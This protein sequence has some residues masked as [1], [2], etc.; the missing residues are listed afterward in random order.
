MPPDLFLPM[1]SLTWP[2]PI[3]I[4]FPFSAN[5]SIDYTVNPRPSSFVSLS[6]ANLSRMHCVSFFVLPEGDVKSE[7]FGLWYHVRV[8][9]E[10]LWTLKIIFHKVNVRWCSSKSP[11][12]EQNLTLIT[13]FRLKKKRCLIFLLYFMELTQSSI[14]NHY[15]G[16]YNIR[17]L[18]R[19]YG[20]GTT[21]NNNK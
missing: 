21:L 2:W 6:Y 11:L 18:T 19:C 17:K 5:Q 9:F 15:I 10:H 16:S 20:N 13:H 8:S 4:L 14:D 7:A 1:F 12:L 3:L